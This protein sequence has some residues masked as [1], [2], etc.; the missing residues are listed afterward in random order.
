[1]ILT[2]KQV[3]FGRFGNTVDANA[4]HGSWG[5]VALQTAYATCRWIEHHLNVIELNSID[6]IQFSLLIMSLINRRK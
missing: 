6:S 3:E 2:W 1:M 5:L 4:F